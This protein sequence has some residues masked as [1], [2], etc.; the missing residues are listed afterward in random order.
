MAKN[1][2]IQLSPK[3]LKED[4][5]TFISLKATVGYIPMNTAYTIANG[6]KIQGSIKTTADAEQVAIDMLKAARDNKVKAEWDFHNYILGAIEQVIAQFGGDSNQLQ[7]LGRKKKIGIQKIS[8]QT[9]G[10]AACW[11]RIDY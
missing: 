4:E 10:K 2:T 1:Q 9:K 6:D 7:S 5:N 3:K 8:G 11:L